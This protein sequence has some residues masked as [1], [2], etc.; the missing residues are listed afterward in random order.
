MRDAGKVVLKQH[1][2]SGKRDTDHTVQFEPSFNTFVD[3]VKLS[4]GC[5]YF[6]VQVLSLPFNDFAT[7]I[8]QEAREGFYLYAYT[9]HCKYIQIHIN[10]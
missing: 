8:E 10:I 1:R 9:N 6:E 7:C 5:F 4:N 3:D 2:G